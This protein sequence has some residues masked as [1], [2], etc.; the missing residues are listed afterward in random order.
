MRILVWHILKSARVT[1]Q[2]SRVLKDFTE[3]FRISDGAY[4]SDFVIMLLMT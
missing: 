2:H 3:A 1:L 4:S